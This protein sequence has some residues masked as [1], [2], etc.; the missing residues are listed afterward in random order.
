[1]EEIQLEFILLSSEANTH[2][3][4][5]LPSPALTPPHSHQ[6]RH[7]RVLRPLHPFQLRELEKASGEWPSEM[8]RKGGMYE[9]EA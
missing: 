4:S 3:L 9:E 6:P 5:T 8:A 2:A 7:P 1:M